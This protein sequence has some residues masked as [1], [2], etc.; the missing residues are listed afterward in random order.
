LRDS[1][2]RFLLDRFAFTYVPSATVFRLLSSPPNGAKRPQ[3]GRVL[4]VGDPQLS[5]EPARGLLG[6]LGGGPSLGAPARAAALESLSVLPRLAHSADEVRGVAKA[7]K[8]SVVLTGEQASEAALAQRAASGDLRD[9]R[10]LHFAT[11]FITESRPQRV[12]IAL[13]P[14]A[15]GAGRDGVLTARE[16]AHAWELNADLVTLGGCLAARGALL[17]DG[18]EFVG[19]T[20]ALYGAGARSVVASLWEVDDEATA[21]L[22]RRF[23]SN[24]SRGMNAAVALT[25]ARKWL[26]DLRR[27]RE[28]PFAH[29][30]YWAGFVLTGVAE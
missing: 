9:Y 7:W 1:Q 25:E 23:H 12:A 2:G 8:R 20:Q 6:V 24:W 28:R 18:S 17:T 15:T 16:I 29:P 13:T 5:P 11:H 3:E 30:V 26:R 19:L 27:G 22:L 4:V 10:A 21:L 14:S